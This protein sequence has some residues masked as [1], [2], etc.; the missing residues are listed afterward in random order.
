MIQDLWHSVI[1]AADDR[2]ESGQ[3]AKEE[4]LFHCM[5]AKGK[6]EHL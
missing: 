4:R 6:N 2:P 3:A 5:I 1:K